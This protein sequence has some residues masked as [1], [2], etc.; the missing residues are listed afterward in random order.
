MLF[1]LALIVQL[2][3]NV[4]IIPES[5]PFF[6]DILEMVPLEEYGLTILLER[7]PVAAYG[8]VQGY[9][10]LEYATVV[11]RPVPVF[12]WQYDIAAFIADEI[13]IVRRD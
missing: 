5:C 9:Y 8:S 3:A 13:F 10:R 2:F 11:V 7:S 4:L 12:R 1:E 6:P